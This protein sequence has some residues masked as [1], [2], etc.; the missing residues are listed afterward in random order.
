MHNPPEY[1]ERGKH[2]RLK[3]AR[4]SGVPGEGIKNCGRGKLFESV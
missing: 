4:A 1:R 3:N 2:L